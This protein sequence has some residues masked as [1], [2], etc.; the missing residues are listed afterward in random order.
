MPGDRIRYRI[1]I[2]PKTYKK[3]NEEK[4]WN[5]NR[6]KNIKNKYV[7]R[8]TYRIQMRKLV[9]ESACNLNYN[10]IT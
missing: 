10:N 5:W 6:E 8:G 3:N 9:I 4:R 7:T 1:G 2:G